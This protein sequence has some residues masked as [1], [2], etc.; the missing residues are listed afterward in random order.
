MRRVIVMLVLLVCTFYAGYAVGRGGK[1]RALRIRTV[2][3]LHILFPLPASSEKT[4]T[5]LDGI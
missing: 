3:P 1:R 4:A 5:Y 2:F